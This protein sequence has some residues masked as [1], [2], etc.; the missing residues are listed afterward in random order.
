MGLVAGTC[1]E[2]ADGKFAKV[3]WGAGGPVFETGAASIAFPGIGC[4]MV[5]GA[6]P[7]LVTVPLAITGH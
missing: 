4:R 6:R 3:K 2:A 1:R 5:L 7:E